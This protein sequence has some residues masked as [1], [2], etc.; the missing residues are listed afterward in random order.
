[1]VLQRWDPFYELRRIEGLMHRRRQG[2][3]VFVDGHES[4]DWG[5]PLDVVQKDD[6]VKISATLPGVDPDNIEVSIEENVLTIKARTESE[7]ER[8]E[9]AYL[10][11]ERRT[12]SFHRAIRLPD[13]VDA[14]KAQPHYDNGVL[15]ITLP[16]AESKRVKHLKVTGGKALESASK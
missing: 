2:Y 3:T 7:E 5:I 11:R 16:K 15:T 1:M 14:E 13:T 6:E 4:R 9:G 12:G 10:M 8:K